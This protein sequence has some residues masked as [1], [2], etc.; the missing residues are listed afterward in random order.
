[1][2]KSDF[3]FAERAKRKDMIMSLEAAISRLF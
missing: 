2:N 1:M 3:N